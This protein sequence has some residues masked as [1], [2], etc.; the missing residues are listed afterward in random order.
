MLRAVRTGSEPLAAKTRG[1][2]LNPATRR[3]PSAPV[4]LAEPRV[5]PEKSPPPPAAKRPGPGMLGWGHRPPPQTG[6][7]RIC[8]VR[9]LRIPNKWRPRVACSEARLALH[10]PICENVTSGGR[11]G[12]VKETQSG[13]DLDTAVGTG[14]RGTRAGIPGLTARPSG[15][16]DSP[17]LAPPRRLPGRSSQL[18]EICNLLFLAQY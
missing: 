8:L 3:A 12:R 17:A 7:A 2:P 4:P 16:P 6:P 14:A 1:A 18:P 5:E 9:W 13:E 11:L 15:N 10:F